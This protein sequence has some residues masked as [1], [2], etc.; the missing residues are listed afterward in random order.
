MAADDAA[1]ESSAPPPRPGGCRDISLFEGAPQ[2]LMCPI[3]GGVMVEPRQIAVDGCGH[4]F[5]EACIVRWQNDCGNNCPSCSTPFDDSDITAMKNLK[6]QVL[7]LD[8]VCDNRNKGCTW[9]GKYAFASD[10]HQE[11]EHTERLRCFF[12]MYGCT[13]VGPSQ[14]LDHHLLDQAQHHLQL[15]CE[16]LEAYGDNNEFSIKKTE[17]PQVKQHGGLEEAQ[18]NMFKECVSKEMSATEIAGKFRET[19][20]NVAWSVHKCLRSECD[21][22]IESVVCRIT[23]C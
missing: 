22:H 7:E 13:Y 8:S 14:E 4:I 9:S 17:E 12:W 20:E 1:D 11:C 3:G 23:S 10:H 2:E 21:Q 18:C 15:T 6:L 5:C 19:Y 16:R